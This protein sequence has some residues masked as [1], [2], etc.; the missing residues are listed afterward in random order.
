[1]NVS[2]TI[3]NEYSKVFLISVF[4]DS[5]YLIT[6]PKEIVLVV[7]LTDTAI[8]CF[9]EQV[10]IEESLRKKL[11]KSL[12]FSYFPASIIDEKEFI[13]PDARNIYKRSLYEC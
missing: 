13:Y 3:V 1:M 5:I 8:T 10:E 11:K 4:L 6:Y 7:V 12:I 9:K 2:R